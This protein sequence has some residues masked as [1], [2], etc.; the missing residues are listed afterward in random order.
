MIYS[1]N[2]ALAVA[3]ASL[4][5]PALAQEQSADGNQTAVL[6]GAGASAPVRPGDNALSCEALVSEMNVLSG[7][8]QAA[9]TR[10]QARAQTMVADANEARKPDQPGAA[11]TLGDVAASFVPGAGLLLGAA[12]TLGKTVIASGPTA[13]GPDMAGVAADVGAMQ[14]MILVGQ[15]IEHLS[16]IW[17][18]RSCG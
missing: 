7:Q 5:L 15:R 14:G 4:A 8:V 9:S 1:R 3:L 13:K 12:R 10:M 16:A 6:Q 11:A 2:A 17:R 18:S